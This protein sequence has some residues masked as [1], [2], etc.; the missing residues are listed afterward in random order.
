MFWWVKDSDLCTQLNVVL[1][2][3]RVKDNDLSIQSNV[4]IVF[5]SM[6]MISVS[7]EMYYFIN[8]AAIITTTTVTLRLSLSYIHD[9]QIMFFH[10]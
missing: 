9:K 7:N 5:W 2:F 8:C 3:W 1:V 6:I 10:S 4:A